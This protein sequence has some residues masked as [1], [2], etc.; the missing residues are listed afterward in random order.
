MNPTKFFIKALF[1]ATMVPALLLT[2]CAT[3]TASAATSSTGAVSTISA[4]DTI[5]TSGNLSASQ[6]TSLDWGTSG[7]V[8]KVNVQ[9]G[10]AVKAGE[11]LAILK[12]DSVSAD[13]LTAQSELATAQRALQEVLDSQSALAAAQLAV[14]NAQSAVDTAQK[15][16]DSL[17]RTRASEALVN[18]AQQ[19]IDQARRGVKMA[20]ERYRQV[21][22]KLDSDPKKIAAELALTN[23]QEN[24]DTLIA[25]YNWYT[26]TATPTDAALARATLASA[27]ATLAEAQKEY[28]ILQKGADPVDVAAAQAKVAVAQAE[29][30]QMAIIAPFDGIILTVQTAAGNPVNSGEAAIEMVNLNTLKIDALV[31]ESSISSVA[32]GDKAD[33]SM[34]LLPDATLTGKVT[35]IS[36]IGTTVNGLVKYTVTIA[37][38]PTDQPVRFGATA[39][40]TLYTS[41][42][43]TA[44]AVPVSAIQSDTQGEYVTLVKADG[45]TQRIAVESGDLSNGL[46]TIT[47]TGLQE[48]D[49]VVLGATSTAS[50]TSNSNNN[51]AGGMLPMGGPGGN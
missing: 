4:Q 12:A 40:I 9:I 36:A 49:Q 19:Q 8:E 46:A 48:G 13:I 28:E 6:L 20:A 35:T 1:F 34:D 41:E 25:T 30:N 51:G 44:L 29:V 32:V 17:D 14:A 31:D 2:G 43:H 21:E 37:I 47:A 11:V 27:Q 3:A 39:N 16:V 26:G 50:S 24:L 7:I 5:E 10:Q 23:A 38:D 22:N 42:P 15:A 18:N 33:I 45:S